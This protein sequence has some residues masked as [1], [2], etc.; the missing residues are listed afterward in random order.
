MHTFHFI[1]ATAVYASIG[2]TLASPL[3]DLSPASYI[4]NAGHQQC[5][6]PPNAVCT[7]SMIP[8]TITTEDNVWNFTQWD[9]D[10]ALE[11]FLAIATTRA[12]AGYP[13]VIGGTKNVTRDVEIAAS[14]CTP[15]TPDG[16][17]KEKS[18]ILATHGIGAAREHWNSGFE[19]EKYN[20]VCQSPWSGMLPRHYAAITSIIAL[21]KPPT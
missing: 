11:Q 9:N 1:A 19:P 4:R 15:K 8:L 20:F 10:F 6:Y 17:G 18:V 7:E 16:S 3:E 13:G 21:E 14:F 5:Y 12:G 2:L